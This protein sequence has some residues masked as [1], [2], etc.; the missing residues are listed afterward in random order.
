MKEMFNVKKSESV[1]AMGITFSIEYR[2]FV[3]IA[4]HNEW[5]RNHQV[6]ND[7]MVEDDIRVIKT[8]PHESHTGNPAPRSTQLL[9]RV[10]PSRHEDDD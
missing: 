7:F 10:L 3:L 6:R 4:R 1:S 2:V 5:I 8:S 9:N